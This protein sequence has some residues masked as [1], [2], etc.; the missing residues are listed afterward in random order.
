MKPKRLTELAIEFCKIEVGL[1]SLRKRAYGLP[2]VR[3]GRESEDICRRAA[4]D[5]DSLDEEDKCD[6]CKRRD[7]LDEK[8]RVLLTKRKNCKARMLRAYI[9]EGGRGKSV[10]R[11]CPRG[12]RVM[13]VTK[14]KTPKDEVPF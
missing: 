2:C 11:P 8:V 6:N 14:P 10:M 3:P 9:R 5:G 4:F 12:S 1:K 13:R 7:P